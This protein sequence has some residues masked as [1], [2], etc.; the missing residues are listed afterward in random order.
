M[1][2]NKRMNNK[3]SALVI[4]IIVATF[5]GVLA[6]VLLTMT[7]TNAQ[8]K[9]VD[10]EAKRTFYDA[11]TALDEVTLG[12]ENVLAEAT[13]EA[14]S[15]IFTEFTTLSNDERNEGFQNVIM[16]Q[17]KTKLKFNETVKD[18]SGK[19]PIVYLLQG[20]ITNSDA[21]I[22]SVGSCS[23][24]SSGTKNYLKI[25][26]IKIVYEN[27]DYSNT[28]TTDL[29]INVPVADLSANIP[30]TSNLSFEKYGLICENKLIID[31]K[32]LNVNGD[33]YAGYNGI[34][35]NG[36]ESSAVFTSGNIISKGDI[37]IS[38]TSSS[39]NKVNLATAST[40]KTSRTNIWAKNIVIKDTTGTAIEALAANKKNTD[41]SF[42]NAAV[43]VQDD[44][45]LHSPGS[46]V[47]MSGEYF[48]FGSSQDVEE[49]SS[50]IIIN[51]RN[52]YLDIRSLS[53]LQLAGRS[54]IKTPH[55]SDKVNPGS[56][57]QSFNGLPMGESLT[58]KG[59][60]IAYLVPSACISVKHNPVTWDEFKNGSIDFDFTAIDIPGEFILEEYLVDSENVK[61]KYTEAIN[62]KPNG[63]HVVYFYLNIKEESLTQFFEKYCEKFGTSRMADIFR[64]DFLMT[65][66]VTNA[67]GTVTESGDISS[68]GTIVSEYITG[69]INDMSIL[70]PGSGGIGATAGA[71]SQNFKYWTSYLRSEE[72]QKMK[73]AGY[74]DTKGVVENLINVEL[75]NEINAANGPGDLIM[76]KKEE[77]SNYRVIIID[78][79]GKDAFTITESMKGVVI[80]TG[81]VV[82][83][84]EG[85]N[86]T[87][88]IIA[89]C[90]EM[91]EGVT[92]SS[93]GVIDVKSFSTVIADEQVVKGVLGNTN[94]FKHTFKRG[95]EEVT[96]TLGDF[97]KEP[98]ASSVVYVPEVDD[99]QAQF[100][101]L[102]GLVVYENW[103]KE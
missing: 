13:K 26:A 14:Y 46:K 98:N 35:I 27:G 9:R 17:V 81:D 34:N 53:K 31:N 6:T 57:T 16:D 45:E 72:D 91:K 25:N 83:D 18:A 54:F 90:Q 93:N 85:K 48:G 1:F 52:S 94:F 65:N 10:T 23:Q 41:I 86:F 37:L 63:T 40:S 5:I 28:I 30:S 19:L 82:L 39:G 51:G 60:Q 24:F 96:V 74:S 29:R 4:V 68:M 89:G 20:F 101:S 80:A 7:G 97:F 67:D 56:E 8:T 49:L 102:A 84:L 88:L 70:N 47:I 44:L 92:V 79:Y 12:V 55:K 66:T 75:I 21:E 50:A 42:A 103:T 32:K 43:R 15:T 73:D 3:G 71:L 87:G 62:Q 58:I 59:N 95:D 77:G 22:V 76:D 38:N 33:I 99:Q 64:V 11:E 69:T 36:A 78:N 100:Q 61:D 2:A